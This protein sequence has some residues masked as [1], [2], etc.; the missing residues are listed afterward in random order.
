MKGEV[1]PTVGRLT[2]HVP[3]LVARVALLRR[4]AFPRFTQVVTGARSELVSQV[5]RRL[6]ISCIHHR[7]IN[8]SCFQAVLVV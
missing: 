1:I 6:T 2:P 7:V 3:V 8:A 5:T 4:I